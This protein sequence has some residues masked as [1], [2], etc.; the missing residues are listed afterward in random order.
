MFAV[1]SKELEI[2]GK[3]SKHFVFER[4]NWK[5]LESSALLLFRRKLCFAVL[6]LK[7]LETL[8]VCWLFAVVFQNN[9]KQLE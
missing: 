8:R 6:S 1:N 3:T 2:N 7:E 4:N 5:S 9:W